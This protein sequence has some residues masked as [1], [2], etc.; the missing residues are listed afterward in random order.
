MPVNKGAGAG[1]VRELHAESL[2]CT[3]ANAGTPVGTCQSE[4]FG[5]SAVHLQHARCRDKTLGSRRSPARG[6]G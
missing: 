4:D 5:W 1:F 6:I 3:E 2:T